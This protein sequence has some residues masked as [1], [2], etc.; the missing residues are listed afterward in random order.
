MTDRNRTRT[1]TTGLAFAGALAIG[2]GRMVR[3]RREGDDATK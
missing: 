1:V 3:R 2:T